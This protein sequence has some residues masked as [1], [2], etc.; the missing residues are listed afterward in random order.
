MNGKFEKDVW[1]VNEVQDNIAQFDLWLEPFVTNKK[2]EA[3]PGSQ[4]STLRRLVKAWA[5]KTLPTNNDASCTSF[6]KA[7]RRMRRVE[8]TL[9]DHTVQSRLTVDYKI[10]NS[11][12]RAI[13]MPWHSRDTIAAALEELDE[14]VA[15]LKEQIHCR[16]RKLE[17][18]DMFNLFSPEISI[19]SLDAAVV[20]NWIKELS[21]YLAEDPVQIR[22]ELDELLILMQ[23]AKN[24]RLQGKID[25]WSC[26]STKVYRAN[27]T[28]K[29]IEAVELFF[30]L[31]CQNASLERNFAHK[32][33]FPAEL[34][35]KT[36][37]AKLMCTISL[38]TSALTEF[39]NQL[40]TH[41]TA[42]VRGAFERP[43]HYERI[44]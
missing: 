33:G 23:R 17:V 14:A 15:V 31:S 20:D 24:K 41:K 28:M 21:N 34:H 10:S 35:E 32:K 38:I 43:V 4:D 7:L 18:L 26:I 5:Q 42:Q 19:S 29:V 13:A 27:H 3:V 40:P 11:K 39:Q 1:D 12:S 8:Q 36:V 37:S 6:E 30:V 44:G 25:I 22:R 9:S 16:F 2:C